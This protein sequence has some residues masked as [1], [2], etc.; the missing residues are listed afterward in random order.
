MVRLMSTARNK[1][2][3]GKLLH[4]IPRHRTGPA[5]VLFYLYA[6]MEPTLTVSTDD[7]SYPICYFCFY[8]GGRSCAKCKTAI[9][10]NNKKAQS[11][12]FMFRALS[13]DYD[14]SKELCHT[15]VKEADKIRRVNKKQD[16]KDRSKVRAAAIF[17]LS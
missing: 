8:Q 11:K 5:I 1:A 6:C 4:R 13:I 7:S 17:W 14:K 3:R 9:A 2:S 16:I 15:C 12:P 10:V